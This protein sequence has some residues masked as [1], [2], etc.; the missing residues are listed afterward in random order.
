MEK[1]LVFLHS[2]GLGD[3]KNTQSPAGI[4]HIRS[5]LAE[6]ARLEFELKSLS[7]LGLN[8]SANSVYSYLR[9]FYIMLGI[10][11]KAQCVVIYHSLAFVPFLFMFI[12]FKNKIILQFNE[13]YTEYSG[14]K[15]K[16]TVELFYLR[17]FNKYILANSSL[18]QYIPNSAM[19]VTRGGYLNINELGDYQ[20]LDEN[21]FVYTGR[22]DEWK[23]GNLSISK[24]L[25]KSRPPQVKMT[26]HIFGPDAEELK[27]FAASYNSVD[28]FLNSTEKEMKATFRGVQF[29]L[30]LQSSS[31]S[32]NSTSFPSKVYK[33][34]SHGV[35]PVCIGTSIIN[36]SE[37]TNYLACIDNWKWS[38]ILSAESV[39]IS[40]N[41]LCQLK[42]IRWNQIKKLLV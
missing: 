41:E 17:H 27:S 31:K 4:N 11:K 8:N 16:K 42:N 26:F 13:V 7:D 12:F 10:L 29:G 25:I 28:V 22:I 32:F 18:M 2:T 39:V 9:G 30:V 6:H 40:R 21:H 34:I 37:V 5:F 1:D 38:E 35:T 3:S 33:Y 19:H 36:N 15:L 23:M 24:Y 14:S 20:F